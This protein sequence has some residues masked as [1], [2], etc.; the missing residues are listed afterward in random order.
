MFQTLI[1]LA[2][3]AGA[4]ASPVKLDS[5]ALKTTQSDIT[6]HQ[7]CNSTQRRMLEKGFASVGTA[8]LLA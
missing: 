8:H 7:S 2:V 5:R 1:S 3:L 4:I 6:I